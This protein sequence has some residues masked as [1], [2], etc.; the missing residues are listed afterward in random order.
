[1]NDIILWECYPEADVSLTAFFQTVK[2]L[3]VIKTN[4]NT[5]NPKFYEDVSLPI[6]D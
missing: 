5:E 1:M 6:S 2:I 4:L 3:T